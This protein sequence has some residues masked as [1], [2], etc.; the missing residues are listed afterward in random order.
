MNVLDAVNSVQC[1]ETHIICV[2]N[3]EE[4]WVSD[5]FDCWTLQQ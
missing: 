5:E 3:S 4:L 1:G 2:E